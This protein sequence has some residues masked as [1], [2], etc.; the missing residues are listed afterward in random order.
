MEAIPTDNTLVRNDT[1]LLSAVLG[2]V[3]LMIWRKDVDDDLLDK[4][5]ADVQKTRKVILG[6]YAVI[7]VIETDRIPPSDQVRARLLEMVKHRPSRSRCNA[8]VI[9]NEGFLASISRAV[10]TELDLAVKS[11]DRK[12]FTDVKSATRWVAEKLE[13]DLVWSDL[14]AD[15]INYH[16]KIMKTA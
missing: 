6:D 4:V 5:L 16:R 9:Q 2:D 13:R 7:T 11:P 3:V 15:Q 10:L 14:L 12:V 8:S 1:N